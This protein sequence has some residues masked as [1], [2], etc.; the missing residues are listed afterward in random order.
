MHSIAL[1]AAFSITYRNIL[2]S[3]ITQYGID[4]NQDYSDGRQARTAGRIDHL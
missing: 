2:L 4:I 3:N 1:T